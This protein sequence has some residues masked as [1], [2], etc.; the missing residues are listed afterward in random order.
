MQTTK[1]VIPA[2][3]TGVTKQGE[4]NDCAVRAIANVTGKSY[5]E[6][7]AVL[8][9]HGR[10]DRHGTYYPTSLAAMQELGFIGIPMQRDWWGLHLKAPIAGKKTLNQVVQDLPIGK[11]VVY[12]RGHA[13]ALV[14]GKIIDTFDQSKQKPVKVIW[15]SPEISFAKE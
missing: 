12:V 10:K 15:Y 6:V 8:K 11:F 4:H 14:N 3:S 2:A 1:R 9:K 7:H 5:D 13:T